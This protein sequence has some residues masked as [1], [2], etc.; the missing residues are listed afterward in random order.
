MSA[1]LGRQGKQVGQLATSCQRQSGRWLISVSPKI[2]MKYEAWKIKICV[3]AS[4]GHVFQPWVRC[5]QLLRKQTSVPHTRPDT[6]RGR[7]LMLHSRQLDNRCNDMGSMT[8]LIHRSIQQ[9]KMST[10]Y[11]HV[12]EDACHLKHHALQANPTPSIQTTHPQAE[13]AET[14]KAAKSKIRASKDLS[15]RP[16]WEALLQ[17]ASGGERFP[18]KPTA[19][20]GAIMAYGSGSF[21]FARAVLPQTT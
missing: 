12:T 20:D 9:P 17:R 2:S 10:N 18:A 5:R 7:I 16:A 14:Q 8:M 4:N 19:L 11:P 6:H 3:V 13:V 1:R 15:T 21:C